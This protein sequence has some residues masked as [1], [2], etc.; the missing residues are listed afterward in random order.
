MMRMRERYNEDPAF[1][2]MVDTLTAAM[3]AGQV[4]PTEARE[5][6]MLAQIMYEDR[7]PRPLVFTR[8]EFLGGRV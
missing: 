2:M 1:R 7:H 5:A 3:E 6:A 4:T 8:E